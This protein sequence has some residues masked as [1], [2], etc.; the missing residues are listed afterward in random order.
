MGGEQKLEVIL[1][2]K[3]CQKE[4]IQFCGRNMGFGRIIREL[5]EFRDLYISYHRKEPFVNDVFHY[6]MAYIEESSNKLL[7]DISYVNKKRKFVMSKTVPKVERKKFFNVMN[8]LTK[9]KEGRKILRKTI[10]QEINRKYSENDR[11]Y[12]IPIEGAINMV[13]NMYELYFKI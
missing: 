1:S 10:I 6:E 11:Q 8:D 5:L 12:D 13:F 4:R 9:K 3:D 7:K 2:A